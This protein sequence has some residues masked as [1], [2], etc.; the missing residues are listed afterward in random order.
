MIKPKVICCMGKFA[1][2][3]LLNQDVPISKI[4]GRFQD[5]S[6]IKLMPTFHPAYLLRNPDAKALVWKD[7]RKIM[8]E[9]KK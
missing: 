3:A 8:A 4:R 1:C 5:Y 2:H 6:G 9:L 7:M